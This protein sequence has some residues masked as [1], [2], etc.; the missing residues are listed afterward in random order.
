MV[1]LTDILKEILLEEKKKADRCLRI[2]RRKNPKSSAYRSGNIERCRQGDI[3]VGLK[4]NLTSIPVERV[5]KPNGA[6]GNQGVTTDQIKDILKNVLHLLVPENAT[7]REMV[8]LFKK[9]KK[10]IDNLLDFTKKNPIVIL[11]LPDGTIHI[12]DGH[13]RAFLLHQAGIKE[14]PVIEK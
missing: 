6:I 4:E 2:A 7:M 8:D 5:L 14:L 1:K 9:D 11:E 12:K 10:N 3:W 13:H